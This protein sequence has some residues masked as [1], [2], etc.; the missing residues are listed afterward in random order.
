MNETVY[1]ECLLCHNKSVGQWEAI[2]KQTKQTLKNLWNFLVSYF[3][4]FTLHYPWKSQ[5]K[6]QSFI[7][8]NSVTPLAN[9]K[10]KNQDSWKLHIIIS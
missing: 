6:Q 4:S 3:F 10:A 2:P 9:S 5:T 8:G 7:A 1:E